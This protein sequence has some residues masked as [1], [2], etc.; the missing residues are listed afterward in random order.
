MERNAVLAQ[1]DKAGVSG[2]IKS[3]NLPVT[4]KLW[5]QGHLT[6]FQFLMELNRLASRTFNDL[7]QH[8]VLISVS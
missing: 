3:A 1:L 5:R 6:N 8:P 4:T 7:M 2:K